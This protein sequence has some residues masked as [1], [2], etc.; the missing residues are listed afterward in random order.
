MSNTA[1]VVPDFPSWRQTNP[2]G[3]FSD[4]LKAS[5][6]DQWRAAT[7]H[8]FTDAWGDAAL[9]KANLENYLIQDHRFIDR[10][11]ALLAATVSRAPSLKDRIP[12]CQFLALVTGEENTYFERSF[13][14]LGVSDDKRENMP[15]WPTT[16]AFKQLMK[17]ATD[18]NSYANMLA[19][20]TVAEGTYLGWA[21]RVNKA[22]AKRPDDFW[23]SE[24]I[25]LHTGVYFESVV[26]YLNTQL[27]QVGPS[28]S[29]EER[30]ECL[31][32]FKRATDL[33]CQFFD[34]AWGPQE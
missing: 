30:A 8:V 10:F 14:A 26:A 1:K 13:A 12:G 25:D 23:Y 33:E 27:D 11:V 21:D 5:C 18:S 34:T 19:V 16:A 2:N 17:D 22:I 28:L 29:D 7:H 24:W 3:V 31:S 4:W 32:C 15:D 20:L 6:A 9:P